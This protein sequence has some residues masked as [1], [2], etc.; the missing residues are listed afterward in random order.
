MHRNAVSKKLVLSRNVF[1]FCLFLYK[2]ILKTEF[3]KSVPMPTDVTYRYIS[4]TES[5]LTQ[6]EPIGSRCPESC[7]NNG[8]VKCVSAIITTVLFLRCFLGPVSLWLANNG[9]TTVNS[10]V[11]VYNPVWKIQTFL[12]E[13]SIVVNIVIVFF[14]M[15][16]NNQF[17][18]SIK[19]DEEFCFVLKKVNM[20]LKL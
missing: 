3:S 6:C 11:F 16:L 9:V 1:F 12:S 8:Q 14:L 10:V 18:M 4:M 20:E 19:T 5:G 15:Y 17:N 7:W 13:N 2:V